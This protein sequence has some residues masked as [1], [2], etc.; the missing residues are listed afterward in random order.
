M[1]VSFNATA[2]GGNVLVNLSA[3]DG[4]SV[5]QS[6]LES[7]VTLVSEGTT[8]ITFEVAENTST[9]SRSDQ[10]T[11]NACGTTYQVTINQAAG[12]DPD[13]DPAC[14]FDVPVTSYSIPAEE[15]K[16]DIQVSR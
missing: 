4:Y 13:P 16:F 5:Q 9:S 6:S 8:R 15:N 10:I 14:V 7:W 11:I 3:T 12:S 2:A 1:Y